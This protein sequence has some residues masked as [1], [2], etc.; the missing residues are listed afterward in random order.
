M[1]DLASLIQN[2]IS[3][4]SRAFEEIV[5]RFQD[6]AYGY[7]YSILR[8]FHLAEDAT[9]E[10]FIEA[11]LNLPR[12]RDAEKFPGWFRRIVLYRC[13]RILRKDKH[14]TVPL[15][16]AQDI[17]SSDPS[18]HV[19]AEALE[20]KEKVTEAIHSLSQPLREVTTLFY[21]NGYTKSE[22][23]E[24]LEV[25]VNT[26][27]SRL[28]SSR[29]QLRE[30]MI[31]I[32]RETFEEH[33]LPDDFAQKGARPRRSFMGQPEIDYW[34][35]SMIETYG[36]A[37]DLFVTVGKPLQVES[38]GKLRPVSVEPEVD[39]LTPFQ[40]EVF[41]LNIIRN[42]HRMLRAL[43]SEGACD[44][45]YRLG[46]TV[47]F[48]ANIF[49]QKGHLSTVLRRLAEAAPTLDMLGLPPV[50]Y[51]M[52]AERNGLILTTGAVGSGKTTTLAAL[53]DKINQDLPVHIVTLEDPVEFIHPHK[54]A[55]LNQRELGTDFASFPAGLRF[56]LRQAAKVIMVGE[57][58][59][60]E[61]VELALA[62]AETGHLVLSTLHTA[63]AGQTINRI[64]GMF[65]ADEQRQVRIRVAEAVRHVVCQ[66]LLPRVGGGRVAALE[67]MCTSPIVRD[68]LINGESEGKTFYSAIEADATL[69]MQTFD[70]SI[71]DLLLE[72][73]ITTET[74]LAYASRREAIQK[75]LDSIRTENAVKGRGSTPPSLDKVAAEEQVSGKRKPEQNELVEEAKQRTDSPKPDRVS[76][77]PPKPPDTGWL[78]SDSPSTGDTPLALV[79]MKKGPDRET[80]ADAFSRNGY[81]L[82]YPE[83]ADDGIQRMLHRNYEAV[84]LHVS[85]EGVGLAESTFHRYMRHLDM[86]KRRGILY[87]LVGRE[88][89]TLYDLQALAHSANAVV[90]HGDVNHMSTIL[91]EVKNDYEELFGYYVEMLRASGIP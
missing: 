23:S 6:M 63:D 12:L 11:Y 78:S 84:A 74:A 61:T 5:V 70:Q 38:G 39:E 22:I 83:T 73:K 57:L 30:R 77:S 86:E 36:D 1:P 49:R 15:E 88:L 32:V 14:H 85:F 34:I 31:P 10:A 56:A 52:A 90:N 43:I 89:H 46:K 55:T 67:I 64:V 53:M 58:R 35:A 80:L 44:L 54:L 59:D 3:G 29:R 87:V 18:P 45:S 75:A 28:N 60:R 72:G 50:F 20:M 4:D 69:G 33:R 7:A 62:A 17:P 82:E 26:V 8:D 2:A 51:R 48:R 91:M 47:R 76:A 65:G 41:A 9:Q 42:D 19:S 25:P 79:L 37:W 13:N 66:R 81:R 27:K 40:A 16:E 21:I 68:T 24:F 71:V